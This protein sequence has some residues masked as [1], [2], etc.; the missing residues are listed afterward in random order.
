MGD[1]KIRLCDIYIYVK[2][3]KLRVMEKIIVKDLTLQAVRKSAEN[4]EV[5][6]AEVVE[7]RAYY[8]EGRRMK[9]L[10]RIEYLA[11]NFDKFLMFNPEYEQTG[12]MQIAM[13][14]TK[15]VGAY[16]LGNTEYLDDMLVSR[17]PMRGAR[18]FVA[19]LGEARNCASAHRRFQRCLCSETYFI[20]C[21]KDEV[22]LDKL[23]GNNDWM[24]ADRVDHALEIVVKK[25]SGRV[26]KKASW[27][28]FS[29][30][31]FANEFGRVGTYVDRSG[32][33]KLI[34]CM[35]NSGT[36]VPDIAEDAIKL[37]K[38]ER[39]GEYIDIV[40][41]LIRF[42]MLSDNII[43]RVSADNIEEIIR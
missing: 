3:L 41:Q 36:I 40:N 10:E 43:G 15:D 7:K 11:Q 14:A 22:H 16:Q 17:N 12:L 35:A 31:E 21:D 34:L 8:R 30:K 13:S 25:L 27:Y 5:E 29:Y 33:K 42:R 2:F 37:T 39:N 4:A 28:V 24:Y 9:P 26:E 20:T 38:I 19:S 1:D 6:N 23:L 32:Q 18:Y